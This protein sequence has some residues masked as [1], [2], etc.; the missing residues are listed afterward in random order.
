MLLI[1]DII[2][3]LKEIIFVFDLYKE[4]LLSSDRTFALC[5][6]GPRFMSTENDYIG[7]DMKYL[8]ERPW[9]EATSQSR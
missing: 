6:E 3:L 7:N 1:L 4:G 2:I 8:R 5:T 9:R